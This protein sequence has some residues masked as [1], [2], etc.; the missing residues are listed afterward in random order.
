MVSKILLGLAGL[1]L[2]HR[3]QE[4]PSPAASTWVIDKRPNTPSVKIITADCLASQDFLSM[5]FTMLAIL[6]FQL[7]DAKNL[8][9]K[10][11]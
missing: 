2:A 7:P 11:A 4:A 8:N 9:S 1:G 3:I 6:D 10:Q 5:P